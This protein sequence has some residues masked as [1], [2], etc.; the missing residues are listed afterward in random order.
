MSKTVHAKRLKDALDEFDPKFAE[1]AL[2]LLADDE[3]KGHETTKEEESLRS[4][5]IKCLEAYERTMSMLDR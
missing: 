4:R 5:L 2:D 3:D 1:K